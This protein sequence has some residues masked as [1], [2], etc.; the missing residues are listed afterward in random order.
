M[1][2]PT[3]ARRAFVLGH[4]IAHSRSP[5]LHSFWLSSLNINGTYAPI[6]L[7]PADLPEFFMRLRGGEFAGG[8]VTIPLKEQIGPLCDEIDVAATKIGAI[9][10]LVQ[11]NGWI[12]GSNS[13]H[14]GFLANL[15][16]HA[17]GWD[18]QTGAALEH[19]IVLGAG[20]ASRAIIYALLQRGIKKISLLNRTLDRA[21]KL[22]RE[23][24]PALN[25]GPLLDFAGRANTA[26]LL[27]NTSAIG[28]HGSAFTDLDLNSLPETALVTDLV[29]TP[30]MTPL[31]LAA[32]ARHLNTV[33]GL[34]M[35]LHQAVPGFEQWFGQRP[36]VTDG[37]RQHIEQDL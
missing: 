25:P 1:T 28:M 20:G 8:N 37:L 30:I 3:D 16:Q 7:D 26:G 15:D 27:V 31:L 19:A 35:L 4:P 12:T 24:G 5:R 33:D 13:D 9:N 2:Q 21:E 18:K 11:R 23:F 32:Q 34:G 36:Q 17:D 29:Y 14:Y 22:A 6:D 10:T